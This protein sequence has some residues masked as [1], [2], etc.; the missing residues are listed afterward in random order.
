MSENLTIQLGWGPR[1]EAA[2]ECAARLEAS[3]R[4]IPAQRDSFSEWLVMPEGGASD[5]S[6][7]LPLP[8]DLNGLTELVQ[9][10]RLKDD[11]GDVMDGSGFALS[12]ARLHN[13][14][15]V[16]YRVRCSADRVRPGN[17]VQFDFPHPGY[18]DPAVAPA[19]TVTEVFANLVLAWRPTYAAVSTYSFRKSQKIRRRSNEIPVGWLTYLS[20]EMHFDRSALSD[21]VDV[22]PLA[23]G[24]ILMLKGTPDQ[25]SLADALTV[26]EAL[27]YVAS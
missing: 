2:P 19:E 6:D 4:D 17:H 26:R 11:R 9:G 8:T 3:I 15:P 12:L 27:G 5:S 24:S 7:L 23:G 16:M 10:S 18:S 14:R 25:P 21:S 20:V 1:V 13:D 22:Q